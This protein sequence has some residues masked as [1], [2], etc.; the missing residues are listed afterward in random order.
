M[1]LKI[2]P[3]FRLRIPRFETHLFHLL[4]EKDFQPRWYTELTWEPPPTPVLMYKNALKIKEFTVPVEIKSKE[5]KL[6]G[7]GIKR[8]P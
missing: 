4:A 3:G 1:F 2:T 7:A 5:G 8:E 6:Q